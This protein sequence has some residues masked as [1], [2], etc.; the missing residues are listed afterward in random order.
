[1]KVKT[2]VTLSEEALKAI[3][4]LAGRGGNRS[5]VVEAAVLQFAAARDRLARDARDRERIDRHADALN[6]E[7]LDV[8]GYQADL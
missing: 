1:M 2:S 8:L 4:R 5:R 7:A 6:R 3:D